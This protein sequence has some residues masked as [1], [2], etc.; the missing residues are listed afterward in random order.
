MI[1]ANV[2][3]SESTARRHAKTIASRRSALADDRAK[4]QQLQIG[5]TDPDT[6]P[7]GARNLALP[8]EVAL[9]PV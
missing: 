2:V 7:H 9:A 4:R 8:V 6:P 1:E 5:D 3:L